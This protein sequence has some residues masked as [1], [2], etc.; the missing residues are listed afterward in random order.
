MR[1]RKQQRKKHKKSRE[2]E[3]N[4]IDYPTIDSFMAPISL[5]FVQKRTQNKINILIQKK[6][7]VH[8]ERAKNRKKHTAEQRSEKRA[9]KKAFFPTQKK[10]TEQKLHTQFETP[11]ERLQQGDAGKSI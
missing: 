9:R 3:K 4:I 1:Q 6:M 10:R 11:I 7:C 5:H 8:S 2:N